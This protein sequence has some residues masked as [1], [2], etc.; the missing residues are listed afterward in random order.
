MFEKTDLEMETLDSAEQTDVVDSSEVDD[1]DTDTDTADLDEQTDTEG[2]KDEEPAAPQPE[3]PQAQT[4]QENSQ[5]AA[6]RRVSERQTQALQE[7]GDN[8]AKERGFSDFA[9]M[10]QTAAIEAQMNSG[11]SEESATAVVEAQTRQAQLES[12]L[13]ELRERD[14]NAAAWGKVLTEFPEITTPGFKMPEEVLKSVS[15]GETPVHAYREYELK[16]LREQVNS[17]KQ[18]AEMKA[19]SIGGLKSAAPSKTKSD[20]FLDG[21]FG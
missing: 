16:R 7:R 21:L 9:H 15:E 18:N 3:L 19:K 20:P 1:T 4:P 13:A 6:A 8:F 17:T 14:Q 12:E 5:I 11:M 10:E 2:A